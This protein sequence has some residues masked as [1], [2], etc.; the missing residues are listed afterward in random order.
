[1]THKHP[2]RA[3]G[4][5]FS[6]D[7]A[8]AEL[9]ALA[10]QQPENREEIL[11]GAAALY[12]EA[13]EY[14]SAVQTYDVLLAG[15]CADRNMVAAYR[16]GA[17]HDAGREDELRAAATELRARHPRDWAPWHF[18]AE[19]F[20]AAGD[21]RAAADWCTVGISHLAGPG[22]PLT[23][24]VITDARLDD[25][26]VTR[27]RVRRVLAEPHDDWDEAADRAHAQRADF[28]GGSGHTLDELH[29]HPPV[30]PQ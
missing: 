7:A 8:A 6:P 30:G 10:E 5:S 27:H 13:G 26:L 28:I 24:S 14:D 12:E 19:T 25:L 20:E 2:R 29:D 11:Q 21:P 3:P 9:L 15:E 1:M 22:T 23:D 17:L 16:I 18:V 4:P